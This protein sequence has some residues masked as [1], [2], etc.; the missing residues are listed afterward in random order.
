MKRGR[1]RVGVRGELTCIKVEEK[2]GILE[3]GRGD[4]RSASREYRYKGKKR[5]GG[6]GRGGCV[7]TYV[8]KLVCVMSPL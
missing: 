6:E 7:S 8:S 1:G 3:N 2:R 4:N 5:R